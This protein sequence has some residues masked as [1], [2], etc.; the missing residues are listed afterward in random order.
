MTYFSIVHIQSIFISPLRHAS[1][2]GYGL[3]HIGILSVIGYDNNSCIIRI[4]S[5]LVKLK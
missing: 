5:R 2:E 1:A 4:L 3:V